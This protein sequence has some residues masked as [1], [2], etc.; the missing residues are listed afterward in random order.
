MKTINILEKHD[1][2]QKGDWC[3]PLFLCTMSGGLSDSY[4]F[5]SFGTPENNTKWCRVERIMPYW[6]GGTIKKFEK[7]TQEDQYEY[8]RGDLPTEHIHADAESSVYDAYLKDGV[9]DH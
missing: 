3:R 5:S 2:L 8:M 7:A 9:Y 6:I 4:S 1:V